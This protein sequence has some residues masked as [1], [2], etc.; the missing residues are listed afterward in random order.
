VTLP[1]LSAD[2]LAALRSRL[3]LWAI[4][5][6]PPALRRIFRFASFREAFGFMAAVAAIAEQRNH[7]PEWCNVY[8]T[9]D[10]RLTTHD[11]GGVTA[12]D[13]ELA[14]AIDSLAQGHR[15]PIDL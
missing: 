11:S 8:T 13:V 5:T 3:P 4:D 15:P 7:H 2:D 1:R 10:V 12:A 6:E 9:V 14:Q